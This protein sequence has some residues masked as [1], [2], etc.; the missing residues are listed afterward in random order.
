MQGKIFAI[1]LIVL[2]VYILS[3]VLSGKEA[4]EERRKSPELFHIGCYDI[5][6][7]LTHSQE[8]HQ[9]IS[10]LAQQFNRTSAARVVSLGARIES[11]VYSP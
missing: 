10:H 4:K 11:S 1:A 3:S 7:P 9:H 5:D 2:G 6:R 8:L